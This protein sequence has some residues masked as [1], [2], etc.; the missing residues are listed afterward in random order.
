MSVMQERRAF[1]RVTAELPVVWSRADDDGEPGPRFDGSTVDVS[2]GGIKMLTPAPVEQ[3]EQVQLEVRYAPPPILV[4]VDATIVRVDRPAPAAYSCALRFD[5]LD[6]YVEQRLVRWVYAEQRRAAD[7]HASARVPLQLVVTCRALGRDGPI[8]G[9]PFRAGMLDIAGDGMR[10]LTDRML[11]RGQS[12]RLDLE[13]G[14]PPSP[15]SLAASVIGEWPADDGRRAY[16]VRFEGLE[17]HIQRAIAER[18][19]AHEQRLRRRTAGS[20]P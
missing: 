6:R 1:L 9:G 2:A 19:S 10:L 18:A 17:P 16:D 15:L 8:L 13:L 5:G 20:T 11:T 7:R 12:L 3:G 14:D 4:F